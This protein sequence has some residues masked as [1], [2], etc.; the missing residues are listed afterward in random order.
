MY[1]LLA[2][3]YDTLPEAEAARSALVSLSSRYLVDVADALVA[4]GNGAGRIRLAR[5]VDMWPES[6]SGRPIWG[7]LA[8]ILHR[9][10]R[11]GPF[12]ETRGALDDHGVGDAFMDQ[13]AAQLTRRGAVLF[14][15]ARRANAN[16]VLECLHQ[17]LGDVLRSD[18]HRPTALAQRD[19]A[20]LGLRAG[21]AA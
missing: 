15:L 4:T 1:E 9:H 11:V 13:V 17:G 5:L 3:A 18:F 2:I 19:P 8:G 12:T 10:P 14:V 16:H 20:E 6:L 7:T 21:L